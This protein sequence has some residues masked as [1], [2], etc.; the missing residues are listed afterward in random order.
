MRWNKDN[1]H[2]VVAREKLFSMLYE[3]KII[4][5]YWINGHKEVPTME[6]YDGTVIE[7]D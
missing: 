5:N 6:F 7:L 3:F 4:K 1:G 2:L